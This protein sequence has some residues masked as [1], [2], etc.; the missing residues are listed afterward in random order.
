MI[1]QGVKV[2]GWG[3]DAISY[4]ELIE[5]AFQHGHLDM[6]KHAI[7]HDPD[8]LKWNVKSACG[9]AMAAGHM[10]MLKYVIEELK[11]DLSQYRSSPYEMYAGNAIKNG[12]DD[13]FEY[14]FR[15]ELESNFFGKENFLKEVTEAA[16]QAGHDRFLKTFLGIGALQA[17]GLEQDYNVLSLLSCSASVFPLLLQQEQEVTKGVRIKMLKQATARLLY[18]AREPLLVDSLKREKLSL[19]ENLYLKWLH[20]KAGVRAFRN[21]NPATAAMRLHQAGVPRFLWGR[22]IKAGYQRAQTWIKKIGHIPQDCI[23]LN[24]DHVKPAVFKDVAA[25]LEKEGMGGEWVARY[26]YHT[27]ALF[28]TTENVLRYLEKWG[29]GDA[30]EPLHD[31]IHSI[32][33]PR[34]GKPDIESWRSAVMQ[35]GPK[36]AKLVAFSDRISAPLKGADGRQYSYHKTR[37]EVAQFAYKKAV[38][39]PALAQMAQR[40]AWRAHYFNEALKIT[41]SYRKKHGAA[42]KKRDGRIPDINIDGSDFDLPGYRFYKLDDGD[43]R[44]LALGEFTNCCQHIAGAGA[45]CAEHG[46][47]SKNGGF[48]VVGRY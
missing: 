15:D 42:G 39:D 10:H 23:E 25:L 5:P 35:H 21:G 30:Q 8:V 7:A 37:D 19:R 22:K 43:P 34:H 16:M 40:L 9:H 33:I 32:D 1:Q 4:G 11:L 13:A 36:M 31:I 6:L 26:A 44:G 28:G 20:L 38:Q 29:Q 41:R 46:F 18:D 2:E 24:P 27:A 48:Y 45:D 47:M 14:V 17:F 12:H 3:K